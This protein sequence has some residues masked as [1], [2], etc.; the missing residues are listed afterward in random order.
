MNFYWQ[1][2]HVENNEITKE[3]KNVW[4]EIFEWVQAIVAAIVIAMFLRTYVFTLANVSGDSMFPTL[5]NNDRLFV[6]R[7]GY[8]AQVDDIIIFRP[9]GHE[10]TPYVKRIIATEGQTVNIVPV[11][12]QSYCEVYVDGNLLTEEYINAKISRNSIGNMKYPAVVPEDCVFVMG[13]NRNY[14]KDSRFAE[15][16]MVTTD[17]IIGKAVFRLFPFNS[18]GKIS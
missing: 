5:H 8:T 12:G 7:A 6:W 4:Y 13:D 2:N 14:S 17:S 9:K 3:G 11:A 16:G 18:I 15:V 1:V 10:D